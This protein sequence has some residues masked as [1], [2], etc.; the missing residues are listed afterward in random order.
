MHHFTHTNRQSIHVSINNIIREGAGRSGRLANIIGKAV[1]DTVPLSSPELTSIEAKQESKKKI[2]RCVDKILQLMPIDY[3]ATIKAA[4]SYYSNRRA[5]AYPVPRPAAEK[6]C[7]VWQQG[8]THYL[9][10]KQHLMWNKPE[11][12]LL[13]LEFVSYLTEGN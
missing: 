7:Q 8:G 2:N 13:Y 10:K 12:Q 5:L 11:N 6:E 4:R 1:A 3:D 9:S